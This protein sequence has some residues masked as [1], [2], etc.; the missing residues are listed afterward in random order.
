MDVGDNGIFNPYI[1]IFYGRRRQTAFSTPIFTYFMD[2]GDNGI[3]NPYIYIFYGRRRQRH[4]LSNGT[5]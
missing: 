2:V 1:Y 3:F 4:F 5:T